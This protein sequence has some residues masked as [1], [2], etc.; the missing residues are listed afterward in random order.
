MSVQLVDSCGKDDLKTQFVTREGEYRLM[1][2]SEYS[3]PNRVGYQNNQSNP[4]VRVSLVTLPSQQT[5]QQTVVEN[6]NNQG[7][8][9]GNTNPVPSTKFG[10]ATTNETSNNRDQTHSN[11]TGG[12]SPSCSTPIG[13]DRICFNYGKELY[14]YA[15]R[16]VKKE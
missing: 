2:L 5:S 10:C 15:Y 8:N 4:Q 9:T 12:L 1:T 6:G 3:R 13:G 16:G 14:V 7:G 11:I